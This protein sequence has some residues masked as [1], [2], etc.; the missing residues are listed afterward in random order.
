MIKF[1]LVLMIFFSFLTYAIENGVLSSKEQLIQSGSVAIIFEGGGKE[2]SVCT[3]VRISQEIVMTAWHCVNSFH[4]FPKGVRQ[5]LDPLD[6]QAEL[7]KIKAI[8]FPGMTEDFFE[9]YQFI[10]FFGYVHDIALIF[11]EQKSDKFFLPISG[12]LDT[13]KINLTQFGYGMVYHEPTQDS[14]PLSILSNG[15]IN[16]TTLES[17]ISIKNS[18]SSLR[19]GDSGG[20]LIQN[21]TTGASI[22]GIL[23]NAHPGS[24]EEIMDGSSNYTK[25]ALFLNWINSFA[26]NAKESSRISRDNQYPLEK[27]I[28]LTANNIVSV[29]KKLCENLNLKYGSKWILNDEGDCLPTDK[30]TC[31]KVSSG[32]FPVSWDDSTGNCRY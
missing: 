8:T 13:A 22:V 28:F 10:P 17:Q 23:S 14:Y 3:G 6:K 25:I 26:S 7:E 4:V 29:Y 2:E 31:I 24:L 15:I 5:S 18:K 27:D 32:Y 11:L 1:L 20:P 9:Y 12:V 21:L 30:E 16:F 19:D